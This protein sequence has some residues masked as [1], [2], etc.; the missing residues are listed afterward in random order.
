MFWAWFIDKDC[1]YE[2]CVDLFKQPPLL[3]AVL[4]VFKGL[5]FGRS[6][7]AGVFAGTVA[8][9]YTGPCGPL[10]ALLK[11]IQISLAPPAVCWR[12][13]PAQLPRCIQVSVALCWH[14]WNVYR[15][16][17]P[18]QLRI[19]CVAGGLAGC[20][21]PE[22]HNTLWHW[23]QIFL[24]IVFGSCLSE[25][26][27]MLLSNPSILIRTWSLYLI[28]YCICIEVPVDSS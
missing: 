28:P 11:C 24:A 6:S 4:N 27:A 21:T 16:L 2:L 12:S 9:M 5:G 10:L 23:L 13:L 3:V 18:L 20:L 14:S 19:I 15:F 22:L 25:I 1:K 7:Q 17:W 26:N 8:E